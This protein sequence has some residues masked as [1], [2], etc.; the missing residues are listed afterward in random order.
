MIGGCH[1]TI[2]SP[3]REMV[4]PHGQAAMDERGER[5]K[6][7]GRVVRVL[8]RNAPGT[9]ELEKA[10]QALVR[11]GAEILGDA[12]E[13]RVAGSDWLDAHVVLGPPLRKGGAAGSSTVHRRRR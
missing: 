11:L 6:R 4:T 7:V 3:G 5:T 9:D 8:E 13:L 2:L 12:G 1:G 10:A